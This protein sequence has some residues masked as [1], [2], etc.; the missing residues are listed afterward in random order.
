MKRL[1]TIILLS[2]FPITTGSSQSILSDTSGQIE[3]NQKI[4]QLD[5]IRVQKQVSLDLLEYRIEKMKDSL[6]KK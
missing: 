3:F 1:P 6:P 2:L 5:S 4:K